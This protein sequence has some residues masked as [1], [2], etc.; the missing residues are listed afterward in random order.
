VDSENHFVSYMKVESSAG[1]QSQV[2]CS[3]QNIE[4]DKILSK[5]VIFI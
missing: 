1:S 5:D 2:S 3:P 4:D